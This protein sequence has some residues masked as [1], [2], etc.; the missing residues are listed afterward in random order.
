MPT[1]FSEI[2]FETTTFVEWA[3][4]AVTNRHSLSLVTGLIVSFGSPIRVHYH[5]PSMFVTTVSTMR[6]QIQSRNYFVTIF[7][8]AEC[9]FLQIYFINSIFMGARDGL[10]L[11]NLSNFCSTN[12]HDADR[13]THLEM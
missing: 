4:F 10:S 2:V 13:K 6:T 9:S 12:L 5:H 11:T 3:C 8:S 7:A 1:S